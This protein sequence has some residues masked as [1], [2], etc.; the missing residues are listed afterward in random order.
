MNIWSGAGSLENHIHGSG[1]KR[2]AKGYWEENRRRI[3]D[4]VDKFPYLEGYDEL[5]IGAFLLSCRCQ[6]RIFAT[7]T[8]TVMQMTHTKITGHA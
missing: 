8:R 6:H 3:G 2:L 4:I 1:E 7:C 5:N